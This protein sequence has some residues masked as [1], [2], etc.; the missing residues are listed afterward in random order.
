MKDPHLHTLLQE[1]VEINAEFNT[2][3][4]LPDRIMRKIR[5][6][7]PSEEQFF[8]MIWFAFKPVILAS[9]LFVLG[10]LSYNTFISRSYEVPPTTT[11][12]VFGLQPLTL[13]TAYSTDLD[14]SPS[15]IP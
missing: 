13:T 4:F 14:E 2:Q 12:I 5:T 6:I 9:V 3:P 11:E 10:F 8:Q 7:N 1:A 15:T